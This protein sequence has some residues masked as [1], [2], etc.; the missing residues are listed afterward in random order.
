V[1][2]RIDNNKIGE[3][4]ALALV[5]MLGKNKTLTAVFLTST[6]EVASKDPRITLF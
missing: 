1:V 2:H 5:E 6:P 4:G 3:A